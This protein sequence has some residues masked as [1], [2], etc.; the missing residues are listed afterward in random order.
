MMYVKI[1]H[2]KL[3]FG[4]VTSFSL[5]SNLVLIGPWIVEII[6]YSH[7]ILIKNFG[8]TNWTDIFN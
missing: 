8:L 5:S 6:Y 2:V 4:N 1:L 3:K 7:K